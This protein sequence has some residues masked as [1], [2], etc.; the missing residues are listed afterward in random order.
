[1]LGEGKK[2]VRTKS[3][4]QEK[5]MQEPG[6][7]QCEACEVHACEI[8]EYDRLIALGDEFTVG[9]LHYELTPSYS[10][11][12]N[13]TSNQNIIIILSHSAPTRFSLGFIS[14]LLAIF[15]RMRYK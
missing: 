6:D 11:S 2:L 8:Q 9:T 3:T 13:E 10:I 4:W 12:L 15:V 14:L 7:F 5:V 1:M